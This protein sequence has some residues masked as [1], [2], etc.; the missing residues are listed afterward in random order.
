M[1]AVIKSNS[2]N[3]KSVTNLLTRLNQE[4]ILTDNSEII[5]TAQKVIFPGQGE[6]ASTMTYLK[7][8][9]LD[10]VIKNLTQPFLGICLG[11]QILTRFSEENQTECLAIVPLQVKKFQADKNHKVPQVGWNQVFDLKNPLFKNIPEKSYFYFIHSYYIPAN[12]FQASATNF[13]LD[14]CSSFNYKNFY[15]VQ[16][17]PEKSG[18][19]GERLMSNFLSL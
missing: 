15:G 4:W 14:F 13:T 2:G 1:I 8:K 19:M 16:F 12:Q 5:K 17:H 11:M 9:K 6:A 7:E 18:E 3:F 10:V